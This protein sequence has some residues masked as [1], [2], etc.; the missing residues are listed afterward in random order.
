MHLQ[1]KQ[2]GQFYFASP[3]KWGLLLKERSCLFS[4]VTVDPILKGLCHSRKQTGIQ[5]SCF[6]F[7][8]IA[9]RKA[10]LHTIL[11]FLSAIQLKQNIC[12]F[13]YKGKVF[14]LRN[15]LKNL[16]LSCKTDL[17]L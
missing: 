14:P 17:D 8:P 9:L 11:A 10:K 16:N 4:P 7:S 13:G 2:L 3:L 1:G 12:S 6:S 15:D 5:I